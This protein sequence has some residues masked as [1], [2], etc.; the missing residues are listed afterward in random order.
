M[1]ASC[2]FSF[3]RNHDIMYNVTCLKTQYKNKVEKTNT[4]QLQIHALRRHWKPD[5]ERQTFF[6]GWTVGLATSQ[7]PAY[8]E[9]LTIYYKQLQCKARLKLK[10]NLIVRCIKRPNVGCMGLGQHVNY[11]A[12]FVCKWSCFSFDSRI[13]QFD[14]VCCMRSPTGSQALHQRELVRQT[15]R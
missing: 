3:G 2:A 8:N 11:R 14:R 7:G 10:Q 15:V 6:P 12:D 1:E 5:M 9:R 13:V 4:K